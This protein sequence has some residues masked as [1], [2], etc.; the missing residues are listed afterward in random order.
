MSKSP[1]NNTSSRGEQQG[2][3]LE[4]WDSRLWL[5]EADPDLLI[6]G[7]HPTHQRMPRRNGLGMSTLVNTLLIGLNTQG[8][9]QVSPVN[10]VMLSLEH[11]LKKLPVVVDIEC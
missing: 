2:V 3:P 4:S 7:V 6:C 11:E 5:T 9:S 1:V 10:P 8:L